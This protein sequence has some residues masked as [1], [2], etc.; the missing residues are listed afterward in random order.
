[1]AS[2]SEARE[3]PIEQLWDEIDDV[4]AGM[5]G[6]EGSSSH[7]Q[8]MAPFTDRKTNTIWFFTKKDSDL[9]Q[10]LKPG[11][12]GMFCIIG[13]DHDYHACLSGALEE[14]L[15]KEKVDRYWS[16]T[17]EAWYHEGKSD[18]NL[19]L[20]ALHLDDGSIWAS[21]G[22]ALKFGWEIAKANM[23]DNKEP[24]VGVHRRVTF[25]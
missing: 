17:V 25:A 21:T 1:M 11:K 6:I 22:S 20:L 23:N 24:D 8:P 14:R 19:T 5:L 2:F 15:D 12:R 7:L 10:E 3:T 18:P 16:A 13:K 9:V 4:H